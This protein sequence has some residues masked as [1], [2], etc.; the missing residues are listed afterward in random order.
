MLTDEDLE[1][2]CPDWQ[3]SD[4]DTEASGSDS[5]VR[6]RTQ[7]VFTSLWRTT[8]VLRVLAD[9]Q[10]QIQIV[11]YPEDFYED[12]SDAE[13]GSKCRYCSLPLGTK[14]DCSYHEGC[15]LQNLLKRHKAQP[16]ETMA[17]RRRRGRRGNKEKT[18]PQ[19]DPGRRS[20]AA[21]VQT[22]RRQLTNQKS[23][24][25]KMSAAAAPRNTTTRSTQAIPPAPPFIPNLGCT[26]CPSECSLDPDSQS[27][28]SDSDVC[29]SCFSS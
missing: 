23:P 10:V 20:S 11:C 19:V 1:P 8:L 6:C 14:E 3:R 13:E 2:D 28:V 4:T 21:A 25:G 27:S 26:P 9:A 5:N 29:S 17:G 16:A 24:Q 18:G 15:C 7:C 22:P 12:D